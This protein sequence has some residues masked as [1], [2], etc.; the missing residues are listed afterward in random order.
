MHRVR[1]LVMAELGVKP[2]RWI[3]FFVLFSLPLGTSA[4]CLLQGTHLD[5]P[6]ITAETIDGSP[7]RDLGIG[8]EFWPCSETPPVLCA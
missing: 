3:L 6:G 1:S 8:S 5:E 7:R 2:R 4:R